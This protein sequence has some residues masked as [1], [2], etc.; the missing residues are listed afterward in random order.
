MNNIEELKKVI[1]DAHEDYKAAIKA[2][3][4]YSDKASAKAYAKAGRVYM[5]AHEK[6][7]RIYTKA[8]KKAFEEAGG[9]VASRRLDEARKALKSLDE[10][11]VK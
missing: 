11:L 1:A 4:K 9:E 3:N 5:R 7:D 2:A 6:A 8:H 10:E